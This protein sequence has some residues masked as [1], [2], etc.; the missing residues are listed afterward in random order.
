MISSIVFILLFGIAVFVF[1]RNVSK[2]SKNIRLGRP[3]DRSDHPAERL[4]I[5][6]LVALGQSKM[7]KRPIAGILHILVYVGFVLINIE[8]VEIIVDGIFG[9]HRF[10]APVLGS[11]Y[12]YMIGFFEILAFLVL[13]SCIIFLIRRNG[14]NIKRFRA[15]ELTAWP[16]LD[17]N[18][19]LI[20]EIVL[21]IA[22]LKMNAADHVLQSRGVEHYSEAGAFPVSSAMFFFF[23]NFSNDVLIFTER[24]SWWVHIIGIFFFLNYIPFSKHFHIVLAFPNV[25]YSKLT[26]LGRFDNM[27]AVTKE[28]K[29]MFD[30]DA[31]P[32]AAP[33]PQQE[34]EEPQRFGARDVRDLTWKQLMDAYSCTECGR[35]TA[36]C[37]ANITGK[38]L[39][40]RKIMMDTR[41]RLAEVG[42]NIEKHGKDYDDGKSLLGNYITR[43]E[44]WACTTCN[45]CTWS[46]PVNIDPLSIIMDMRRSLVM[47]ESSAPSELASMFT[48]V[49]NNGAPW[50]FSQADRLN[51][52]NEK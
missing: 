20:F 2:I 31:D 13:V 27:E 40:P 38:L 26:P 37:P 3:T 44:L 41:D 6:S 22:F 30:P 48:N 1:Y 21:M 33:P 34:G 10:L 45:A 52:A 7:V 12:D 46:C 23:D 17:A 11:F 47:E 36:N 19:I 39:S 25:Y 16:R 28:V 24:L 42:K 4:K 5:M 51:W 49:E 35:C 43:E 14:L 32:Y 15:R 18:L 8:I 29:L 9:T 50:Q